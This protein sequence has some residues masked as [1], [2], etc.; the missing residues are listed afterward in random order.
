MKSVFVKNFDFSIFLSEEIIN[1]FVQIL[2]DKTST[3][4]EITEILHILINLLTPMESIKFDEETLFSL[5][6]VLV[7]KIFPKKSTSLIKSLVS[8]KFLFL[9]DSFFGQFSL[10]LRRNL[11][12][13][14]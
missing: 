6:D 5:L 12:L 4:Q 10:K 11:R 8:F 2:R 7:Y 14:Y 3:E 13:P 1:T 9:G